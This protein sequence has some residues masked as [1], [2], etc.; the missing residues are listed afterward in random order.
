MKVALMVVMAM[1]HVY[2]QLEIDL[3]GI[4]YMYRFLSRV[5]ISLLGT[6]SEMHNNTLYIELKYTIYMK[7]FKKEKF[8][9]YIA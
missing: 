5:H 4:M 1:F 2:H 6:L 9:S 3:V 7:I 8:C